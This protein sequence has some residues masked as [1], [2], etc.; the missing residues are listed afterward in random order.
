MAT[1]SAPQNNPPPPPHEETAGAVERLRRWFAPLPPAGKAAT[2]GAALLGAG[3][4][5]YGLR[6]FAAKSRELAEYGG[7]DGA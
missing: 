4:C 3:A 7:D 6:W 1:A 5:A 2:V